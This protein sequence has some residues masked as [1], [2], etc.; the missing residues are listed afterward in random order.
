MAEKLAEAD[1]KWLRRLQPVALD[2]FCQRVLDEVCRLAGDADR[3][4]HDRYLALYRFVRDRDD[5]LS[6]A[7]DGPT[8]S[9]ALLQLARLRVEG[10]VT[11]DEFTGFTPSTRSVVEALIAARPEQAGSSRPASE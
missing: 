3:S 8:R 9:K 7:F 6:A 2:R 4:R 1:W 10:L 5:A 11:D